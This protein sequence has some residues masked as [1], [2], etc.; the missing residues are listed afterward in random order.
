M[1]RSFLNVVCGQKFSCLIPNVS[2]TWVLLKLAQVPL[3]VPLPLLSTLQQPLAS[4]SST[5]PR[6]LPQV[7]APGLERA[8]RLDACP[9]VL[10]S[11]FCWP[12]LL[13]PPCPGKLSSAMAPDAHGRP[14]AGGRAVRVF[15]P[16]AADHCAPGASGVRW[17]GRPLCPWSCEKRPQHSETA[18]AGK[19]EQ[20]SAVDAGVSRGRVASP[21]AVECRAPSSGVLSWLPAATLCSQGLCRA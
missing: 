17:A 12:Q 13:E 21:G 10:V 7:E 14:Q 8:P 19:A 18:G 2:S 11:A 16:R 6:S 9:R 3:G 1:S 20:P 4:C 15:T 5:C